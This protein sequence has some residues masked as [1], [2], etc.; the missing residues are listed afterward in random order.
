MEVLLIIVVI[1][2]VAASLV[3]G[4][5]QE[6]KRTSALEGFAQGRGLRF[7]PQVD[8]SADE[9][10]ARF[11]MFRRGH[12]RRAWN[13]ATGEVQLGSYRARVETGDFLYKVTSGSGKH[14]STTTY[15]FSYLVLTNPIGRCPETIVRREGFFDRVK[16]VLGFDDIDF[17]SVEFSRRFHVSSDDK[18]FA[19]DLIDPR[20]MEFLLA[21]A[22]PAL[23]VDGGL[24]CLSNGKGR[25]E[26]AEFRARLA[27]LG[28]FLEHWPRHL[29]DSMPA[30][31][32][33][34]GDRSEGGLGWFS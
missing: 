24:I 31:A 23:E 27:W 29:A 26:P 34:E 30:A 2:I 8:P 11:A 6:K 16:G 3:Y 14:Q 19:Y 15:R 1:G 17:E 25:W 10:F 13:I 32:P 7:S 28:S 12:S 9:R 5:L 20:M 33:G 4:H 21:S 18:R 22:P